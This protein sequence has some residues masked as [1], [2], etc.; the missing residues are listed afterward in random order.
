MTEPATNPAAIQLEL[1][2]AFSL[3]PSWVIRKGRMAGRPVIALEFL[4]ALLSVED[5]PDLVTV[6]PGT[7]DPAAG[8]LDRSLSA[9][10]HDDYGDLVAEKWDDDLS[11]LAQEFPAALFRG[12]LSEPG[13]IWV[14]LELDPD[15]V[16][17]SPAPPLPPADLTRR[18]FQ[19]GDAL[20]QLHGDDRLHLDVS[21]DWPDTELAGLSPLGP[22]GADYRWCADQRDDLRFLARAET[23][24]PELLDIS[25]KAGIGPWTD[26]YQ[27]SAV[28][29]HLATGEPRPSWA[30][31]G[32]EARDL[33]DAQPQLEG[34]DAVKSVIA[35]GL[36]P[37]IARRPATVAA[38]L[39]GLERPAEAA[40]AAEPIP[41]LTTPAAAPQQTAPAK[42]PVNTPPQQP[43]KQTLERPNPAKR[44][45]AAQLRDSLPG[46]LAAGLVAGSWPL[47]LSAAEPLTIQADSPLA[48][49]IWL[50][51]AVMIGLTHGAA[52]PAF[53]KAF[54]PTLPVASYLAFLWKFDFDMRYLA[55]AGLFGIGL[56]GLVA[57]VLPAVLQTTAFRQRWSKGSAAAA[58]ALALAL[59]FTGMIYGSGAQATGTDAGAATEAASEAAASPS[60]SPT[61]SPTEE[62]AA[63]ETA[64]AM[65]WD[66][67]V[68]SW[69]LNGESC[70][71]AWTFETANSIVSPSGTI[72]N[73]ETVGEA[74][75]AGTLT[76]RRTTTTVDGE[77][78]PAIKDR[79]V[80]TLDGSRLTMKNIDVSGA[81]PFDF[82]SCP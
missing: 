36:E 3:T 75:S 71:Q 2:L 6:R 73:F 30:M 40:V 56:A 69:A 66:R 17:A 9:H 47:W 21:P 54:R 13:T 34:H 33:L 23:T 29:F 79:Y 35:A 10:A 46:G 7:A 51:Q 50:A 41:L 62:V 18:A 16:P 37:V 65:G 27:A 59:N 19:I 70:A 26:I 38:W 48:P 52:M 78:R 12:W 53:L 39:E 20:E 61:P 15:T 22:G 31:S 82:K 60:P 68:G 32:K 24:P 42:A 58:A 45:K 14:V 49:T 5:D 67:L 28:L 72:W 74:D 55:Q 43:I 8:D 81:D 44:S 63:S 25:Q 80:F 4:P 64:S 76:M 57:F 1:E 11:G 77:V